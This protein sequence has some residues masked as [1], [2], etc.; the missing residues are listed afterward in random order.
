LTPFP[1]E[2]KNQH[3]ITRLI[4]IECRKAVVIST[5]GSTSM[6]T[7]VILVGLGC[8]LAL[9]GVKKKTDELPEAKVDYLNQIQS[10]VPPA[11]TLPA[12]SLN[13]PSSGHPN[14][15]ISRKPLFANSGWNFDSQRYGPSFDISKL[16]PPKETKPPQ[17]IS[18]QWQNFWK[19]PR[20]TVKEWNEP[21]K[22]IGHVLIELVS[23]VWALLSFIIPI[24]V[25]AIAAL[26]GAA[27]L[28]W[29]VQAIMPGL[30]K[31]QARINQ[32]SALYRTVLSAGLGSGFGLVL[33]MALYELMHQDVDEV[34][35][36][37]GTIAIV[38]CGVVIF[39]EPLTEWFRERL[40]LQGEY[41]VQH[42]RQR[43][44]L[45]GAAIGILA[46]ASLSHA[47]LH[48]NI[49]K[50]P[51]EA[52][53]LLVF[54]FLIPAAITYAWIRGARSANTPASIVG[55]ATGAIL[56]AGFLMAIFAADIHNEARLDSHERLIFIVSN[57]L[58]WGAAGLFGGWAIDKAWGANPIRS[59]AV[60]VVIS[61][62][63]AGLISGTE[64]SVLFQDLA[65]ALGW[66]GGL[67]SVEPLA[68]S[69][70]GARA[71]HPAHQP[72]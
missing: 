48:E 16:L 57:A 53:I 47:L 8:S 58:K 59:A 63:L 54:A 23:L 6:R 17:S 60:A 49:R 14:I 11:P 66:A 67:I 26:A 12:P 62:V 70:I 1:V 5:L 69:A 36:D 24:L 10:V 44:Y 27:A 4:Y 19:N 50:H 45:R 55:A 9:F 34:F 35:L 56:G 33:G 71:L 43:W 25:V 46:L 40:G 7:R 32:D 20:E 68:D 3:W 30:K 64:F 42:S 52:I 22:S 15:G 51:P 18:E 41:A 21:W 61:M 39:I 37:F 13:T 28:Y 29:I 38:A 65:R 2:A 72:T 31:V